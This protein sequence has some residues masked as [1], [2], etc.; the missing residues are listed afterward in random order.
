MMNKSIDAKIFFLSPSEKDRKRIEELI[1]KEFCEA[2]ILEN[3]DIPEKL[4]P[5]VEKSILVIDSN[6]YNAEISLDQYLSKLLNVCGDS[7]MRVYIVVDSPRTFEYEKVYTVDRSAADDDSKV[8]QIVEELKSRGERGYIR[9]GNH[10][11]RIAY[12]RM[13]LGSRWRTGV[14]HDISASGMS[15]S[16]DRFEDIDV[17]D[18]TR[19]IEI[20]IRDQIFRLTGKFLIRRTFKNSN[21]F[22]IVFSNR[23]GSGYSES[24]NSIIF[25]LSREQM[26]SRIE[27]FV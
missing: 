18:T 27:K 9:F 3:L 22:I 15:C 19:E 16:F 6:T 11:T 24:L 26:L 14:V 5:R 25:H 7:L 13:K 17:E 4:C 1:E 21:T 20:R 10:T 2:F 23:R 8:L 12:F